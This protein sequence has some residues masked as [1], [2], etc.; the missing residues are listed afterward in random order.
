MEDRLLRNVLRRSANR[1]LPSMAAFTLLGVALYSFAAAETDI[2]ATSHAPP[3]PQ[4]FKAQYQ[5][6]IRGWPSATITH[7]LNNEGSHW[8]SDMRFSVAV[9]RG[10]ER[11][12]FS[13]SD[14]Q[15][16][17]FLYNS[18]YSLFGVGSRYQLDEDELRTFDRQTALFDLS[19]RT[20]DE[21]CTAQ[22]PCD[23]AFV[24]HRGRDEHFQYYVMAPDTITVPAG[25]FEARRVTLVDTDKPDRHLRINFHPEWPGLILSARYEKEGSRQTQLTMTE[26]TPTKVDTP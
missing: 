13:V 15:T 22:T 1:P 7:T 18:S 4:P 5:L 11:S 2:Q 14:E 24:D 19:R 6:E 21:H 12:R 20:G 3:A 10:Q 26:F 17:A 16:H 9:A 8:L 25:E 23:I